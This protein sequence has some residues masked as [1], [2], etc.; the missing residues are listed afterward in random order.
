MTAKRADS[1]SRPA[2]FRLFGEQVDIV[3]EVTA[4]PSPDSAARYLA[5]GAE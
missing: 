5:R 2:F 4:A 3:P 1:L